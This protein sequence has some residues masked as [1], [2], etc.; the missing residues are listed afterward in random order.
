MFPLLSRARAG[1]VALPVL[2]TIAVGCAQPPTRPEAVREP[3]PVRVDPMRVE[4]SASRNEVLATV[5]DYLAYALEHNPAVGAAVEHWRARAERVPQL[6]AWS[7]PQLTI[8]YFLEEVQTRT[9]PQEAKLGLRQAVPWPGLLGGREEAAAAEARAA[10]RRL[11]A[12]R[13][14]IV[15]RVRVALHEL[16]YLDRS[17]E[18]TGRNLELLRSFESVIRTRYRV[19]EGSHP[20]L[21]RA[22]VALGQ[23]DDRCRQLEEFRPTLVAELNALLG[24]GAGA[25]DPVPE[26]SDAVIDVELERLTERA[27]DQNPGLLAL[28]EEID[29][30]RRL[31][32]VAQRSGYPS[33][34]VGVDYIFTGSAV[35]GGTRGSGDDPVLLTLGVDLP[36]A[37]S[38]Y[39]AARRE[40]TARR[41]AATHDWNDERNR[42]ASAVQRGWFEH[43]DADR[44]ARLYAGALVPK[45]TESLEA[46]L[47]GFRS[48]TSTFLDVLDAER[49]LLE[50]ELERERARADR[51]QSLARLN[52]L[53]GGRLGTRDADASEDR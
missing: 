8:G 31:E 29:A 16:R 50:F 1:G 18:I 23:L 11:E 9:G 33:F 48:G 43:H 51:A 46:S 39:R 12:L 28:L 47:A 26:L 15:E 41:V 14:S 49:T 25:I 35:N 3:V 44:R 24:R 30:Q 32:D 6:G 45:A 38:K 7:D 22:Q 37:R 10:W 52:T 4:G 34:M 13:W 36:I 42:L 27:R 19:G 20:A 2:A 17:I 21:I 40:A 53:V 5:D